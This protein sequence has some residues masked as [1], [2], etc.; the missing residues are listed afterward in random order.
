MRT[1]GMSERHERVLIILENLP[2]ERDARVQRECAAL[3]DAGYEVSVIA[4]AGA[5]R[6]AG[7]GPRVT[8]HTYPAP[9]EPRTKIGFAFEFAYSWLAAV[10]L[11]LRV[12]V[13]PGFDV[14]QACNP[15][16]LYFLLAAPLKLLGKRFV[17][18]HHDLAPELF[19]VRF[20]RRHRLIFGFLKALEHA[21]LRMAD[22]VIATNESIADRARA[23]RA[24][25]PETVSVVRNGPELAATRR[26]PP[27]TELKCKRAYL[28]CWVGV[29]GAPDEGLDLALAAIEHLVRV[30]GRDDCH[31][32]FLGDGPA[33]PDLRELVD[34]LELA[35][36]VTLTG[37]VG[38]DVVF[39]YL[40][41]A[42]V[43]LQPDPWNERLDRATAIK[44]ME[45][46]AF[47]VPVVAFD[48]HET[49]VS[50]G[51][52]AVYAPPNDAL[53]LAELVS[54]LL[55]DPDRRAAMGRC[56]RERVE[57]E[58]AWDHQKASYV[59]VF[60]RLLSGRAATETV[61]AQERKLSPSPARSRQP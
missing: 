57:R 18:D 49:R 31:F 14:L 50:A 4:R 34:R 11:T 5:S 53:A 52:A 12:L 33:F 20:G 48:L 45:Y 41:T 25:R 51:D 42:D 7:A 24:A 22:H 28:C 54:S 16:D 40:S 15:P 46:M 44:T 21:S 29:M 19:A 38:Q 32:A 58:L 61:S 3:V 17:F 26:R 60:D 35:E 43:A 27:R 23:A 6:G 39:D 10:L 30:K 8:V 59:T 9:P 13:R 56:G 2:L 47:S 1:S 55:D 36:F 37:W